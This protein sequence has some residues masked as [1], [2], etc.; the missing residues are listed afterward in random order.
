[1]DKDNHLYHGSRAGFSAFD[2]SF[3]GTG[4]SGN[5]DACWFGSKI[6]GAWSHAV[7]YNRNAGEP[8]V[9]ICTVGEGA[10]LVDHAKTLMEQPVVAGRLIKY[11]PKSLLKPNIVELGPSEWHNFCYPERKNWRGKYVPS[12]SLDDNEL[13]ALYKKCGFHGVKNWGDPSGD[14]LHETLT[15]MFDF[16]VLNIDDVIFNMDD[17]S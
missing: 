1:M 6:K 4:E 2:V 7:G 14:P 15:I 11:F 9:Y 16:S 17:C 13:I 3:K 12:R 10:I 5:I 8:R